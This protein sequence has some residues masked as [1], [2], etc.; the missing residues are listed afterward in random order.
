MMIVWILSLELA[1]LL[2]ENNMSFE[3]S[4]A[5]KQIAEMQKAIDG[6]G[7]SL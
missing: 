7:R 4:E 5:K 3:L 1:E 6:F 2:E